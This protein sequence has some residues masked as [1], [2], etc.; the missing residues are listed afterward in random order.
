MGG[1]PSQG[2]ADIFLN[3]GVLPFRPF[4]FNATPLLQLGR[5]GVGLEPITRS[6]TSWVTP[7]ALSYLIHVRHAQFSGEIMND[8]LIM[9]IFDVATPRQCPTLPKGQCIYQDPLLHGQVE[10]VRLGYRP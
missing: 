9:K 3:T 7:L 6:T 8:A 2:Q 5:Y 1:W 4:E 10:A